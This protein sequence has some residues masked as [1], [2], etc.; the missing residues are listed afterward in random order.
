DCGVSG[1]GSIDGGHL[2]PELRTRLRAAIGPAAAATFGALWFLWKIGGWTI[3]SP[4][5]LEPVMVE[6]WS[7]HVLGWLFFR[8]ER[9]TLPLGTISGWLY[10]FGTTLGYADAIPWVALVL[11]PF[12]GLL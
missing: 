3:V 10:P 6:D 11:R 8:N 9:I 4:F 7:T 5:R 2:A 1:V 12:S